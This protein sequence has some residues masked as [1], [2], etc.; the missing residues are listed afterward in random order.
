MNS[1]HCSGAA[2]EQ[3]MSRFVI[4]R[5][6]WR[7]AALT[8]GVCCALIVATSSSAEAQRAFGRAA[9]DQNSDQIT[10]APRPLTRLLREGKQALSENR[11][12]DGIAAL[13]SLLLEEASD[14]LSAEELKQ[15]FF[16][17]PGVKGLYL[18]SVRG[19]ALKLLGNLPE[20]GRKTLEIQYGVAARLALQKAIAGHDIKAIGDVTRMYYHTDAGYDAGILLA[21]DK[22]IR[23]YPLAA[24]GIMQR[25]SQYP[26]ARNRFG[27]QLFAELAAAWSAADRIDL[28]KA[29]LDQGSKDFPGAVV[30]L[31]GSRTSLDAGTDWRTLLT[32]S[33]PKENQGTEQSVRDWMMT[34]GAADRNASV[35]A[36][37]PLPTAQWHKTLHRDQGDEENV[38]AILVRE[39]Q[40]GRVMMPRM[41]TRTVG[42]LLFCKR[43]NSVV[44]ALDL[45]NGLIKWL[46]YA[47]GA[48]VDLVPPQPSIPLTD[49]D[50][51]AAGE[52]KRKVWGSAAFGQFTCDHNQIYSI[53]A[54]DEQPQQRPLAINPLMNP[55]GG[56]NSISN[57]LAAYSIAAQGKKLWQVGGP[58]GDQEPALAGAFFLGP[59]LS[60]EGQLYALAE[61]N[62]E[63]RLIVLDAATGKLQWSQQLVQSPFVPIAS[64]ASRQAQG[65]TPSIAE[66]VIIC[67]CGNGAVIALDA[68]TRSLLWGYQYV[69]TAPEQMQ[70]NGFGG[71]MMDSMNNFDPAE[72]H[73]Q[74]QTALIAQG[75]V[76]LTPAETDVVLCLDLLTGKPRWNQQGRASGRYIVGVLDNRLIIAGNRQVYALNLTDGRPAWDSDLNLPDR[77]TVAGKG[78]RDGKFY[79][80]PTS[81]REIVKI[82]LQS[83]KFVG[84]V[85][86]DRQLG[87]LF[88][89]RN[90]LISVGPAEVAVYH[91]RDAL[92]KSVES[93]L[94]NDPKNVR[95]LNEQGQLYL[96]DGKIA[97]AVS[98]LKGTLAA[99]PDDVDTRYLLAEALIRAL[100]TDFDRYLPTALEM[101]SIIELQRFR[102]LVLLAKGNLKSRQ[103]ADAFGRLLQLMRDRLSPRAA[104]MQVRSEM[105][106]VEVGHEVDVDGWIASQL[107]VAYRSASP[108][109]QALMRKAVA[110]ELAGL[111]KY[112]PYIKQLQLQYLAWLPPAH[113][114]IVEL[115]KQQLGGIQQTV[116]ER[117]LIPILRSGD[118]ADAS[119]ARVALETP[120]V[121]DL[122]QLGWGRDADLN[123]AVLSPDLPIQ[124]PSTEGDI[125]LR[126]GSLEEFPWPRGAVNAK[127]ERDQQINFN[128]LRLKQ[129]GE[130]YGRPPVEVMLISDE[131][132]LLNSVGQIVGRFMYRGNGRGESIDHM[133][134]VQRDGGLLIVETQNELLAFDIYRGMESPVDAF[135]WK[136]S[137]MTVAPGPLTP[138]RPSTPQQVS[139]PLG[140]S[141][142]SRGTA[143]RE[144]YVGPITPAGISV[145]IGN[146]VS[147]LHPLTGNRLWSRKGYSDRTAIGLKGMEVLIV[148]PAQSL[149]DVV[150]CRDGQLIRKL[151]YSGDWQTWFCSGDKLVQFA[152]RE[153]ERP[154][155]GIQSEDSNDTA[156][157]IL[158][159]STSETIV[160]KVFPSGSRADVC[161]DQH[162][163]IMDGSGK[164]WY[165]NLIDGVIRE[166]TVKL[167]APLESVRIRAFG[168]RVVVMTQ[169]DT[170]LPSG[171]AVHPRLEEM[172]LARGISAVNG[173][174]LALNAKSGELLWDRPGFVHHY[175]Y[176]PN[177]PRSSP[178]LVLHRFVTMAQNA[179]SAS[180]A[181]IDLRDGRLI[182]LND[183]L[184]DGPAQSGVVDSQMVALDPA[185]KRILVYLGAHVIELAFTDD[186]R[187]PQ[188][189]AMF[190]RIVA[191][192]KRAQQ[193]N[194]N[195]L[196]NGNPLPR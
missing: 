30:S 119:A 123:A 181:V 66:S 29:A 53:S 35:T 117:M 83:G 56:R 47:H 5:L 150:D 78:V 147:M 161:D 59:P 74:D 96:A 98:L 133:L 72:E 145:Q 118:E 84:S 57:L 37:L 70:F 152:S 111:P 187:P 189:V 179:A 134:K 171:I 108:D 170:T 153:A 24:A 21:Q 44:Y 48:G 148:D 82:D 79:Y 95:A 26:A 159:L 80:L 65:L 174:L 61:I 135:L 49:E 131:V 182:Y 115:A 160:E 101:E 177:Q 8:V 41:E 185:E 40:A 63:T 55:M 92:A 188:P 99:N 4:A 38:R 93:T 122:Q 6:N 144:A 110:Q 114:T 125:R 190:G 184:P 107:A 175:R 45:D 158:N 39:N 22:L 195:P 67:P 112:H 168:D 14:D 191:P 173:P 76:I 124:L 169:L 155:K 164:L 33:F 11:F 25:L 196:L 77:Q 106:N 154:A 36:G 50:T 34:G 102:F 62:S 126:R 116:A 180:V 87:N 88:A 138:F 46:I 172:I 52:L 58:N 103:Y 17:E 90:Q 64:D 20:E 69:N 156:I 165:C 194:D 176:S 81:G 113:A 54:P 105:L 192:Q 120:A 7:S 28:A 149:I 109:E 121:A 163:A 186:D 3:R 12:T 42:N 27:A 129:K 151:S 146:S 51:V 104:T 193:W 23:G 167:S 178:F 130:A 91:T 136:H 128:G 142:Y 10:P 15:D 9:A 141:L 157:R 137:L 143:T 127:V 85:K 162:I 60:H 140:L 1:V 73:W 16:T 94:A 19:E 18:Q 32:K 2:A 13:S 139:S 100:E 183:K 132:R 166:Q 31:S 97:E 89:H 86:V 75:C 43:T 68:N 71:G